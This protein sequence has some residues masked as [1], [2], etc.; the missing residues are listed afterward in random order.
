MWNVELKPEIKR[1]LK[2]P[3]RFAK[4]MGYAYLGMM[5]VM[6]GVVFMLF[7][8]FARPEHV[9]RPSWILAL[10]FIIVGWGEYQKFKGR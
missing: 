1:G 2:D 4:G 7:L 6:C 9:L 3:D 10:G 8:F 5:I